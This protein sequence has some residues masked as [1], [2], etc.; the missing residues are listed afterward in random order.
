[1]LRVKGQ[2]FI[3]I[4]CWFSI[5]GLVHVVWNRPKKAKSKKGSKKVLKSMSYSFFI[6]FESF[7]TKLKQS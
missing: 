2:G 5:V 4:L 3:L 7:G 1:L 6:G